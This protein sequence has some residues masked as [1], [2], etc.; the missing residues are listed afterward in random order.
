MEFRSVFRVR[1]IRWTRRTCPV[2]LENVRRRAIVKS[3]QMSGEKLEMS[4]EAQND[5]AYSGCVR[6]RHYAISALLLSVIRYF[7][8]C[9][10]PCVAINNI[11]NHAGYIFSTSFLTFLSK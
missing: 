3:N 5:F 8:V 10:Q 1:E 6:R 11:S 2:N 4:D 7:H 9:K